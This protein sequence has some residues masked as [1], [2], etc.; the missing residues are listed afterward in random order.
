M[1]RTLTM[2]ALLISLACADLVSTFVCAR[3]DPGNSKF[4]SFYLYRTRFLGHQ[5]RL[6]EIRD[7]RPIRDARR[8]RESRAARPGRYAG[9]PSRGLLERIATRLGRRPVPQALHDPLPVVARDERADHLARLLQVA[10][11][12]QVETLLLQRPHEPLR[13]PVALRL[14]DERRRVGEAP[15]LDLVH[16]GV[17]RVLTPPVVPQG[18]D[19]GVVGKRGLRPTLPAG[20]RRDDHR[21]RIDAGARRVER[22]ADERHRVPLVRPGAYSSPER[23]NF[24][25]SSP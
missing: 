25:N 2:L 6:T 7:H 16:E 19:Q 5:G 18:H 9:T 15:A 8:A 11:L 14:A 21:G 10:E 1:K 22:L 23:F 20:R 24:R 4:G 12:V 3:E 17:R 13:A